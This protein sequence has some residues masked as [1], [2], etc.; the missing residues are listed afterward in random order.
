LLQR[1]IHASRNG[2]NAAPPALSRGRSGDEWTNKDERG[3][4]GLARKLVKRY[5]I[6]LRHISDI[7]QLDYGMMCKM[8]AHIRRQAARSGLTRV[9]VILENHTKD[10]YDFSHIERFVADVSR[11]QDIKTVKLREIADG[12]RSGIFT[13]RAA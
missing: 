8:M 11:S 6:G 2:N 3:A 5:V 12:L 1:K 9:P 4:L 13:A 7:A 10:I